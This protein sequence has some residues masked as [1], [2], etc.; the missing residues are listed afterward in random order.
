MCRILLTYPQENLVE[1]AQYCSQYC[2]NFKGKSAVTLI[3]YIV[4]IVAVHSVK[5]KLMSVFTFESL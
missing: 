5:N 4:S 2:A 3:S 1:F